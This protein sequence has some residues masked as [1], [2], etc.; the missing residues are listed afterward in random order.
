MTLQEIFDKIL[1]HARTQRRQAA[2]ITELSDG[3]RKISC[4]YRCHD[5]T[6]CFIGALIPDEKY[7]P[8]LE[9]KGVSSIPV[10]AALGYYD[11][12]F[13]ASPLDLFILQRIH[14]CKQP[15]EW[16]DEFKTFAK[17]H[18]LIYTPPA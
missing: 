14:D 17:D 11:R 2:V 8:E 3:K 1:A 4:M 6:K 15:H 5:G 12:T 9:N 13:K 7:K 18:H 10:L 16:E